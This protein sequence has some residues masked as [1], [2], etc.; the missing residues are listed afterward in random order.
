MSVFLDNP[1][2]IR[3]SHPLLGPSSPKNKAHRSALSDC[4]KS[5]LRDDCENTTKMANKRLTT[6]ST[7]AKPSPAL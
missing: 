2:D 7:M 5:L 6:C 1:D 3:I 4:N